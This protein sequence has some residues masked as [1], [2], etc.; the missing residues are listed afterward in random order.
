MNH[1]FLLQHVIESDD[2]EYIKTIGIFSSEDIARSVID[3]IKNNPGFKDYP[4]GFVID[5][6]ILNKVFWGDGFEV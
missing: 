2:N 6:Y 5:K 4:E 1:V 3:D